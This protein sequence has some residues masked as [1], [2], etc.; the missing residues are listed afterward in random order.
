MV[1]GKCFALH[2]G[3][4]INFFLLDM[5]RLSVDIDLTYVPLHD[6]KSS[7]EKINHSLKFINNKINQISSNIQSIHDVKKAKLYIKN[8]L[9]AEIKIEV[10]L[11]NRGIIDVYV[12]RELSSKAKELFSTSFSIPLVPIKQVYGGKICA[13]LSRQSIR[14]RPLH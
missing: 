5:P 3:T 1:D 9:G 4:A 8:H 11:T 13:C 6:R 2:G 12:E 7:I 14:E 10:N